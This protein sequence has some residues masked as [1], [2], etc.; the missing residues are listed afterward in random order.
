MTIGGARKYLVISSLAITASVFVFFLL[1]PALGFP[2]T[3]DQ[4]LRVLEVV[5][6][7][8]LGYLGSA[9][10]FVFRAG[11]Q[12]DAAVFR[13]GAASLAGLLIVGPIAIFTLSLFAIILA[14]GFTNRAGASPGSGISLNQL[15]AGISI[16]LGLLVVTTN[17]AVGYLFGGGENASASDTRSHRPTDPGTS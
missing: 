14:F 11:S 16:I 12:A 9:A 17:V 13:R 6:P 8:F 10:S 7:V 3:F 1:S 4:S 15:T 5:L 2:L